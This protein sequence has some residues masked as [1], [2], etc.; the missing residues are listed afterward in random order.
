MKKFKTHYFISLKTNA[1]LC[2]VSF[3]WESWGRE[4]YCTK[5]IK[6][7]DCK[8]CLKILNKND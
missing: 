7:V 3:S 8:N 6:K 1:S 5:N 4:N 2:G